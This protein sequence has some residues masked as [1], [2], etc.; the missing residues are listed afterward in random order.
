MTERKTISM[1]DEVLEATNPATLAP[2]VAFV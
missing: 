2:I 1:V